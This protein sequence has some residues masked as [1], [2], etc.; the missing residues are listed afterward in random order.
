VNCNT[1]H[2]RA[3]SSSVPGDPTY[4]PFLHDA[5]DQ[6][7]GGFPYKRFDREAYEAA[8]PHPTLR[9]YI[10]L[11]LQN[12]YL[13]LSFL[14]ALGGRV[15]QMIFRLTG[16]NE[17]YQNP[18]I[19]PTH[20]GPPSPPGANW[21]PAI[22][23]IEWGFPVDEHGYEFAV[24]WQYRWLDTSSRR[25]IEF[26]D[27][28]ADRPNVRVQASLERDSVAMH[29]TFRLQNPTSRDVQVKFWSNAMV[30]PGPANTLGSQFQFIYPTRAAIV[31]STSDPDLPGPYQVFSW[32]I[33]KGR[34]FSYPEN[35]RGWVGFFVYPQAEQ[36]WAAVYDH[37]ADEGLVRVFPHTVARGLKGFGFG[38]AIPPSEWTDNGSVYAEMH[39]GLAP[40]FRD[41]ITIP[42]HGIISWS[43]TW[44]PIWRLGGVTQAGPRGAWFLKR[45]GSVLRV[46]LF[47]VRP[48][49][50]LLTL[51]LAGRSLW[52]GKVFVAPESPWR[53]R[54]P[55][56]SGRMIGRA[57]V[58]AQ[59]AV[60][61]HSLLRIEKELVSK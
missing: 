49:R 6:S 12:R 19:K 53:R 50:G 26:W 44:Y 34:D 21:W 17:L 58:S 13:R 36:D 32:P 45:E 29:L 16:N 7:L 40:T 28:G 57:R 8:H 47:T 20:W 42:A 15:Y 11:N 37:G 25:G 46:G 41:W 51:S 27:G 56:P 30:A 33:Y 38:H 23:G 3:N 22:G 48:Y 2:Y 61:G 24:P 18:V 59:F 39:G 1:T 55:L 4:G 52:Q 60:G 9:T 54:I 35:W 31:H 43:E 10:R 14:P 5:R